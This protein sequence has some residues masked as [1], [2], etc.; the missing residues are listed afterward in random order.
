V[1]LT[2]A[3]VAKDKTGIVTKRRFRFLG[4]WID[5]DAETIETPEGVIL[6]WWTPS[7]K[8]KL[9]QVSPRLYVKVEEE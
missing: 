2:G 7:L 8:D 5:R 3:I 9:K 6:S 4:C 1:E